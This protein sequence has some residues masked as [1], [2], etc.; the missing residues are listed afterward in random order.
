M[1]V[2]A[3][4]Y[5]QFGFVFP[6]MGYSSGVFPDRGPIP[7][8]DDP[9]LSLLRWLFFLLC[10]A[11]FVL[12]AFSIRGPE[13]KLLTDTSGPSSKGWLLAAVL[14]ALAILFFVFVA[15]TYADPTQSNPAHELR[16]MVIL[17]FLFALAA[18]VVQ[19]S[20]SSFVARRPSRALV[21]SGDEISNCHPDRGLQPERRDLRFSSSPARDF[22][23]SDQALVLVL[24]VIP[25]AALALVSLF[26]PIFNARGLI[27]VIALPSA[28]AGRRHR[29]SGALPHSRRC[30]LPRCWHRALLRTAGL[31]PRIGRP[32]GL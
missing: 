15:K 19:R 14:A 8:T 11:L 5:L 31:Q 3:R 4:E 1:L 7:L 16:Q 32:G 30:G 23:A 27:L 28:G 12:G 20:W 24:A 17:P 2:Y 25:F 6:L 29:P 13:D 10:L 21:N 18:I 9:H 22:S 26:K